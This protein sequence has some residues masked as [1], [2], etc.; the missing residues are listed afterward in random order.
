MRAT[1]LLLATTL[2]GA[3]VTSLSPAASAGCGDAADVQTS[4]DACA[5]ILAVSL[6]GDA[7][8]EQ[9]EGSIGVSCVTASGTG[10]ATNQ[11]GD[12]SCGTY[13]AAAVGCVALSGTG[14]ATNEAGDSSC[15][16]Y[17]LGAGV[18]CL[19]VSGTGNAANRAGSVSCGTGTYVGLGAGCVAVSGTGTASN[20][21]GGASCG[22]APFA[23]ASAGCVAA[24]GT[25]DAWNRVGPAPCT[26]GSTAS[27]VGPCGYGYLGVG[28]GCFAI[29]GTGRAEN[30]AAPCGTSRIP[31]AA[32]GCASVSGKDIAP[33]PGV[34]LLP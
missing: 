28:A 2:L 8:G 32:V 22:T 12:E 10:S 19:A 34:E 26:P 6:A 11:A 25:G 4:E 15:G 9:C 27:C 17:A 24:S 33:P 7:R 21:V 20:D 31:G 18:G 3:L 14:D 16:A 13:G 30:D 29:S 5:T 1:P 23:F